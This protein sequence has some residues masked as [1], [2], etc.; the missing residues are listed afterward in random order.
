M[1]GEMEHGLTLLNQAEEALQ[2]SGNTHELAYTLERRAYAHLFS[3]DYQAALL[4]AEQALSLA[5][6]KNE[7]R[8][9]RANALKVKAHCWKHLGQVN[10]NLNT[11]KV[12]FGIFTELGYQDDLAIVSADLGA[13]YRLIGAYE[14]AKSAYQVAIDHFHSTSN[15]VNLALLQNN[16]GVTY[17]ATGDYLQA[18]RYLE[19]A[20]INARQSGYKYTEAYALSSIGDLYSDLD[21][22]DAALKAYQD[23]RQVAEH[24]QNRF[25]LIYLD[26]AEAA[27]ACSKGELH[28]ASNLI[29]SARAIAGEGNSTYEQ[30]LCQLGA[31]RLAVAEDDALQAKI[32]LEEVAQY[33]EDGSQRVEAARTRLYLALAYKAAGEMGGALKQL[34]RVFQLA[35][36]LDNQ[37]ILV[38]ADREAKSLLNAVQED[39]SVGHQASQ[40]LQQVTRFEA[41]IPSLRRRLRKQL[42]TVPFAPP[43]LTIRAFGEG[44]VLLNGKLVT[45]PDWVSRKPVRDLFFCLLA[46]PQGLTKEEIGVIFW[47]DNSPTQLKLRFK[48]IVYWLRHALGL[49]V[50]L[51]DENRYRFNQS[52]DYEYDVDAFSRKQT[53]AQASNSLSDRKIAYQDALKLYKGHYL[54]FTDENWATR[55]REHLRQAYLDTGLN[56]GQ[57]LLEGQD[58]RDAL[59]TCQSLIGE[60]P[61]LEAAH[62]IA[63]RAHAALGDRAAVVRQFESC[64]KNLLEEIGVTPSE[65]TRLLHEILKQ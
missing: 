55:E 18:S 20:L 31:G 3:G 38:V 1:L 47:P 63:M 61:C 7:L 24:I 26:L 11:L 15:I 43:H 19:D 4:D 12:V 64:R 13:T 35:S 62:R 65:E 27:L 29:Q 50:V 32:Y 37:H 30:A 8:V 39:P 42:S 34:E 53:Q 25:L 59:E 23:A 58:N 5:G 9:V 28:Q 36:K 57:L 45:H 21:A 41:D 49:D 44:Q 48:N 56:L 10:A 46:H 33:F 17:H 60:N 51:F 2:A 6:Q 40:L 16:A 22:S 14:Q 52:L 54:P